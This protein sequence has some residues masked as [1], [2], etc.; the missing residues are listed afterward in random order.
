MTDKR[1]M[2]DALIERIYE[3]MQADP[4]V[5][6]LSADMGA[7]VLDRLRHDFPRRFINVGIAEQNLINVATGLALEGHVV[8]ALLIAPFIMRA[9]EQARVNL[10]ISGQMRALNVNILGVGCGVSYDL[11]GPTHHCVEDLILMR[12]L[13]H[14][15]V[16]SPSDWRTAADFAEYCRRVPSPKYVRLDGK[17]MPPIYNQPP[18]VDWNKGFCELAKG[19]K[20]CIVSTGVMTQVAR[21]VLAAPSLAGRHVGLVDVFLLKPLDAESL[22]RTIQTY[23]QVVTL[24]EGFIG[25]GG[26][27][28]LVLGLLNRHGAGIALKALGFENRYIFESGS[29]DFLHGRSGF[30]LAEIIRLIEQ[31]ES[32]PH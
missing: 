22:F 3:Q 11:S 16:C 25:C 2:R 27:D 7:P 32:A 14:F 28:D 17:P 21:E 4:R 1:T 30:S 26:L 29:R 20:T 13:P 15:T 23:R 8:Y 5:F 31:L 10:A 12:A 19:E 24:E 9:Y 6:F 18:A